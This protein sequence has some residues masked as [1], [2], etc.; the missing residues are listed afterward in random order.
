MGS[1]QAPAF[2]PPQTCLTLTAGLQVRCFEPQQLWISQHSTI[3]LPHCQT[4]EGLPTATI[5]GGTRLPTSLQGQA[6]PAEASNVPGGQGPAPGSM[7]L[8]CAWKRT[9]KIAILQREGKKQQ[10]KTK[11]NHKLTKLEHRFKAQR[12]PTAGQGGVRT[13]A[14]GL[15]LSSGRR[16][17][18][19]SSSSSPRAWRQATSRKLSSSPS[20]SSEL[21]NLTS[22][23]KPGAGRHSPLQATT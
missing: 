7:C 10:P 12:S 8:C 13:V 19:C 1:F 16:G 17:R 14:G 4:D 21:C 20:P 23:K 15:G 2:D 11:T 5:W 3:S 9:T 22:P 18:I 6:L